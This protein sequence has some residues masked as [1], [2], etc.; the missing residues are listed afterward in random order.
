MISKWARVAI[1]V[2]VVTSVAACKKEDGTTVVPNGRMVLDLAYKEGQISIDVT[3]KS[4]AFLAID[5]V[6]KMRNELTNSAVL[7]DVRRGEEILQPC[8]TIDPPREVVS[9][10]ALEPGES[11]TLTLRMGYLKSVFCL[12]A[13]RYSVQAVYPWGGT[14]PVLS[15]AVDV[16][17]E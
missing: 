17:I 2:G 6:P 5:A 13:G 10:V 7:I 4:E 3:N 8:A 15:N 11:T 12:D 1:F 14:N 9:P 16:E